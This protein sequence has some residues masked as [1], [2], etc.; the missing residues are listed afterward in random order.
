MA[1]F[2]HYMHLVS[3]LQTNHHHQDLQS[4]HYEL[5][6]HHD[7]FVRF[8]FISIVYVTSAF[9]GFFMTGYLPVGFEVHQIPIITTI[10]LQVSLVSS[11]KNQRTGK[12]KDFFLVCRRNYI[13]WV[14]RHLQ[15]TSECICPGYPVWW[16]WQWWWWWWSVWR[17]PTSWLH[18]GVWNF[19]HNV[20]WV[21]LSGDGR[22]RCKLLPGRHPPAGHCHDCHHSLRLQVEIADENHLDWGECQSLAT[23][24][25]IRAVCCGGDLFV[26]S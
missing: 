16:W 24:L 15:W 12:Y 25:K 1:S 5:N 3:P 26:F 17:N 9:L 23:S 6:H 20:R 10:T 21:A 14:R 4:Y 18:P 19:L 7:Q 11:R 22:P 2:L 8:G 13:S